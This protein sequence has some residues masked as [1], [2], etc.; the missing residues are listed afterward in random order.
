MVIYTEIVSTRSPNT[1]ITYTHCHIIYREILKREETEIEIQKG[2]IDKRLDV[3]L[4]TSKFVENH[5][6]REALREKKTAHKIEI[7]LICWLSS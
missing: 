1:L 7:S 3:R 5:F 2:F 6:S 4:T